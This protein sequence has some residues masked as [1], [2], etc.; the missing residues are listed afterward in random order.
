MRYIKVVFLSLSL[1]FCVNS[2]LAQMKI[3]SPHPNLKV[4]VIKASVE[5]AYKK[6]DSKE[7]RLVE[8]EREEHSKSLHYVAHPY[9][10]GGYV[11]ILLENTG[12]EDV[13]IEIVGS[14]LEVEYDLIKPYSYRGPYGHRGNFPYIQWNF[15]NSCIF[16]F[17]PFLDSEKQEWKRE[18]DGK[19]KRMHYIL[20]PGVPLKVS[21][22]ILDTEFSVNEEY[23]NF[24]DYLI[25]VIK[26]KLIINDWGIDGMSNEGQVLK[27]E[28]LKL[29]PK[30]RS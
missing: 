24:K 20:I 17:N 19:V 23:N 18:Y 9:W 15:G 3:T 22:T 30:S 28:N 14:G 21:V 11:Y 12:D 4:D 29:E 5:S 25:K 16:A 26:M 13:E 27:I 7:F 8:I 10:D 6:P 2:L 1:L